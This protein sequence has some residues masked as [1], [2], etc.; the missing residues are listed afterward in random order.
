MKKVFIN[1][2]IDGGVRQFS[3]SIEKY[4]YKDFDFCYLD[5]GWINKLKI[6]KYLFY[7]EV[8]FSSNNIYIYLFL[9]CYP[10]KCNL[11]LHDHKIRTRTSKKEYILNKLFNIFKWRF[12]KVIIHQ[13]NDSCAEKLLKKK[14]IC[15]HYMPPHGFDRKNL[16]IKDKLVLNKNKIKLLCFGRFDDYKNYEYISELVSKTENIELT[17]AGSGNISEKLKKLAENDNIII[18]NRYIDD[19]EL[20]NFIRQC[21][22]MVLCYKN[23]TQTTLI[24]MAGAYYKPVILSNIPEFF[25]FRDKKFSYM[26]NISEKEIA[27]NEIN[28]LK[29]ISIDNYK[30][31]C[32][33]SHEN[34]LKS[35]SMWEGYVKEFY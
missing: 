2:P 21:H 11:I 9:M 30:D 20:P 13:E 33:S 1:F 28:S 34:Y 35:E 6:F 18:H 32:L 3:E 31:M 26:I 25:H 10:F 27:L 7:R 16:Y 22:F 4:I 17:I 15:Y 12:N 5:R 19:D 23:I 29:K 8:W 14:N 24:D